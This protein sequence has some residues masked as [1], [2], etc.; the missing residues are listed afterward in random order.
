[1]PQTTEENDRVGDKMNRGGGDGSTMN[2]QIY[3]RIIKDDL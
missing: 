3:D 2:G 1:M